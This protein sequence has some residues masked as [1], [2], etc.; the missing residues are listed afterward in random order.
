MKTSS[1]I[2]GIILTT[3]ALIGLVISVELCVV[4]FNANFNAGSNPSFCSI[5][6]VIDCDAV[7]ETPFSR[8]LAIPLSLWG[9]GFYALLLFILLFPFKKFELFG[10]FKHPKSYVFTLATFSVIIS[11]IMAYISSFVIQKICILCHILYL[12]NFL[13]FLSCLIGDSIIDLYKNAFIDMKNIFSDKRWV[14]IAAVC[15]LSGIITL[16]FINIYRPFTPLAPPPPVPV[17]DNKPEHQYTIGEIGNTLGSKDAKIVIREFT[18]YECPFCSLS[19]NM[20]LKLTSEIEGIRVEHHDFPLSSEC[21]SIVRGSKHK[22]S[23]LAAYYARA[24]RKQ[25]KFWDMTTLLFENQLDL[26]EKNILKLA[27]T[28]DLDIEKLKKD[29]HDPELQK[30]LENDIKKAKIFGITGTPSYIIGIK[31]YEGMMP[32]SKFKKKI[33]ESL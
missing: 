32:Y 27:K 17:P 9:F 3:I 22:N 12:V 18:D 10:E 19:N 26:S 6:E 14:V 16:V 30:E 28:I 11:V 8:F 21:N 4:Y 24:A 15:A 5:N 29:A 33:T 25:G 20:M 1:K 7:S 13:L 31:K 23:C 2:S